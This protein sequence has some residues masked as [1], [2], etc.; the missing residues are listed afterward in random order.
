[1]TS[2]TDTKTWH[3]ATW[4]FLGWLETGIKLVGILSAV[5]AVTQIVPTESIEIT[6]FLHGLTIAVIGL[7][8]LF[9]LPVIFI[10]IYQREIISILF[11]I[12]N[13]IG[14]LAMLYFAV[15][16]SE[17]SLLPVIFAVAY[18][19]GELVKQRF[20]STIGYT[21]MGQETS[22]MLMLSRGLLFMYVLF[23]ILTL[24]A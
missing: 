13:T 21:E 20:L 15:Y 23:G 1:V 12:M 7:I 4:G 9:I 5:V 24:I 19:F 3:I 14:H 8:T 11:A 2:N 10:R 16:T 6:G 22:Q 18:V 17:Q